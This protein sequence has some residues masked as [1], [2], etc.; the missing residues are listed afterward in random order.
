MVLFDDVAHNILTTY[1][2]STLLDVINIKYNN[3]I[4][5]ILS[6]IY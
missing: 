6:I 1:T 3:Y 5:C 4:Q 2:S